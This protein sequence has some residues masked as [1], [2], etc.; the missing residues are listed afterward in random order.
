MPKVALNLIFIALFVSGVGCGDL[1][2]ASILFDTGEQSITMDTSG[3]GIK[4][5]GGK[6]TIPKIPCTKDATCNAAGLKCG[7]GSFQCA[8]KCQ[9][10]SCA[11]VAAVEQST[12]VDLSQQIKSQNLA[13]GISKVT[14]EYM[15]YT[16]A[17]NSFN[18][19]TPKLQLYIGPGPAKSSKENGVVSFATMPTI[20]R[21]TTSKNQKMNVTEGGK[22]ALQ[23]A[24][25]NYKDPFAFIG[26]ASL[27]FKEGDQVP[28][29]KLV[30]RI[31]GY[32]KVK[33]F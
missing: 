3:L 25:Y 12:K 26:G 20:A 11:F 7:G 16:V 10:K 6:A 13:S 5:P 33:P 15:L 31:R 17:E 19:D 22:G 2:D 14:F 18:F 9:N 28:S 23:S 27:T 30:L 32:F 29:G 1:L 24:I 4:I 8:L 21:K